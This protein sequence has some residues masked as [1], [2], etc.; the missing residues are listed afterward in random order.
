MRSG[1]SATF[2]FFFFLILIRPGFVLG[3]EAQPREREFHLVPSGNEPLTLAHGFIQID[4]FELYVDGR[5]WV[6]EVDYQLLGRSGRIRPLR[7]WVTET[8]AGERAL[9]IAAYRFQPLPLASRRDLRPIGTPPTAEQYSGG[10]PTGLLPKGADLLSPGALSVRGSKSVQVSSGSRREMTVDQNLRLDISGNLTPEISVRAF[11]TD[12]NLPVVPEG[13]TEELRDIDKVLVELTAPRWAATLGDFVARRS[14]SAFGGYRRKLQGISVRARPGP[15]GVEILAG[16]PRGRYRTLQVRGQESNQGPYYLGAESGSENL[17]IV[18]GSERVSLDG[19]L[20]TR[21]AD[22]DYVIDYIRGTVTF[23]YR[24]LITSESNIVLEYEEGEGPYSRTVAGGGVTEEFEIPGLGLAANLG[25]RIVREK[26]DPGRLRTGEL[27]EDDE[28]VLSAAGDDPRLAVASGIVPAEPGTGSYVLATAGLDTYYVYQDEGDY[29]LEFFYAGLGLGDYDLDRLDALGRRIYIYRGDGLG[30]YLIGRTLDRPAGQSLA[31]L[32]AAVGDSSG[33]FLAGEWNLSSN[34]LNLLSDIDDGDNDGIAGRIAGRVADQALGWGSRGFGKWGLAGFHESRDAK[35]RPFQLRK[36]IFHYDAWGLSERARE[37]G[38]LEESD[39]ETGLDAS[40]SAGQ[41]DRRIATRGHYGWLEHGESMEAS[42]GYAEAEWTLFRGRG[43]HREQRA[44]ATDTSNPLDVERTERTHEMSWGVGPFVPTANYTRR[45][46]VNGAANNSA[47]TGYRLTQFG[48]GLSSSVGGGLSWRTSFQRALADSLRDGRWAG[49]RDSRTLQGGVTTGR[50]A[51][52]RMVGEGTWRRTVLP[53][54]AE[55][56]TRLGRANVSGSWIGIGSDWSLGYRVDNSRSRVLDRQVVYVGELQGDYDQDGQ[57]LGIDRGDYDVILAATDSLVATTAVQSDLRWRQGFGFLGK[58]RWYGAWASITQATLL[59]RST[60]DDVVGLLSM[61]PD[62]IF[63]RDHTV[64][65]EFS[66]AEELILLQN[67]KRV[68]VR[69]RLEFN[70]A[71][72]RQYSEHPEDRIA[73]GQILNG[74]FNATARLSLKGRWQRKDDRRYSSE[75]L[76]SARRSFSTLTYTHEFGGVYRVA[77]GSRAALQG[78][79]ITRSDGVSGVG[80]REYALRPETRL[81]I[82]DRWNVQGQ[83]RVAE[84]STTDEGSGS[85][86]WFFPFEGRNI[87]SSLR[88]SWEP[89]KYL[90]VTGN[91]FSRKRSDRGWEHDL[92]LESTARF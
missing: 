80:Q 29:N 54:G 71:L 25:A 16:S 59:G 24:R 18:A 31:T 7:N 21:G 62:V 5:K 61:K 33:T 85:R 2:V 40:W 90:T 45:E 44:A 58:E 88:L 34:D 73:R 47:G 64:L 27:A 35:F 39:R 46:W 72:D 3:D 38:F 82:S 12:D 10:K 1:F 19:D 84:V 37:D 89:T 26:D 68:D 78:E 81:K 42:Q 43:R 57:Y 28:A 63:D 74:T 75:G 4:S 17:F 36:N 51:G 77:S 87:E 91:W 67:H 53:T 15:V 65:S 32:T 8:T 86:P 70:Q 52:M 76:A 22:R 20:L 60:T 56:S 83:M 66:F 50:V 55:E 49:E 23:T 48:Y 11:M 41:K 9:V 69:S 30:A 14:G 13:N 79:Y 6:A 92:R